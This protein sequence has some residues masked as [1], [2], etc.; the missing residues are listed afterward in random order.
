MPN[1]PAPMN[2]N[3]QSLAPF[4]LNY[5]MAPERPVRAYPPAAGA[6]RRCAQ[7]AAFI[8]VAAAGCALADFPKRGTVGIDLNYPGLGIRYF[9]TDRLSWELRGQYEPGAPVVGVRGYYYQVF[10]PWAPTF[11]GI[12][13]DYIANKGRY[14]T[15]QGMAGMVFLGTEVLVRRCFS[16]Q[17]DFGPAWIHLKDSAYDISQSGIE[18]VV[19][20]GLNYYFGG[21]MKESGVVPA[22]KAQAPKKTG[23]EPSPKREKPEPVPAVAPAPVSATTAPETVPSPVPVAAPSTTVLLAPSAVPAAL[24]SATAVVEPSAVPTAQAS[25]TAVVEPSAIPAALASATAVVEPSAIP[26]ALASA[27][28][29]VEPSVV[30]PV[31]VSATAMG[32]PSLPPSAPSSTVAGSTDAPSSPDP[33]EGGKPIE[34]EGQED[35]PIMLPITPSASAQ[36]GENR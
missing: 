15:A 25:A 16:V 22:V 6:A 5:T 24:A 19:N 18:Y 7:A 30:P 34:K 31:S 13:A 3:C 12:E 2:V 23:K 20:F 9:T 4:S 33:G 1:G 17:F 28:A 35:N 27:T 32:E 11:L 36:E 29:V 10:T 21:A 26:A 14:S 8:M